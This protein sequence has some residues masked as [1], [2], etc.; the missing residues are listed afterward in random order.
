MLAQ[1]EDHQAADGSL[2]AVWEGSWF[3]FVKRALG[4][5]VLIYLVQTLLKVWL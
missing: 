3:I 5:F 1:A 2:S 4:F